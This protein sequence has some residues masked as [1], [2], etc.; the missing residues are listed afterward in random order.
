MV[1]L[2][3]FIIVFQTFVFAKIDVFG[4]LGFWEKGQKR[5]SG[6]KTD[7]FVLGILGFWGENA[8]RSNGLKTNLFLKV[9]GKL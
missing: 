3:F 1:F 6:L 2:F 8:K 5:S 9:V 7:L 4:I